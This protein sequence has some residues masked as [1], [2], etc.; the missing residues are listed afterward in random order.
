MCV[1]LIFLLDFFGGFSFCLFHPLDSE[2]CRM[3]SS[4]LMITMIVSSSLGDWFQAPMSSQGD[5]FQAPCDIN[6]KIPKRS[7]FMIVGRLISSSWIYWFQ[8]PG[9]I[10][11]K[12][13]GRLIYGSRVINFKI[14]W[15]SNS[16]I[17]CIWYFQYFPYST[18]LQLFWLAYNL[19]TNPGCN[20]STQ[21]NNCCR[22]E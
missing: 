13:P 2:R 21:R 8:A 4:C 17:H 1:C 5:K 18:S 20:S 16:M 3:K 14:L 19:F 10:D 22:F 6:F 7:F 9:R 11:S 12:L 15:S